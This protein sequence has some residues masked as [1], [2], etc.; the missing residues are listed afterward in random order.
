MLL[1]RLEVLGVEKENQTFIESYYLN[2]YAN[3][4][5]FVMERLRKNGSGFEIKPKKDL[6]KN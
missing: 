4:I 6:I 5:I 3:N 1:N 2:A